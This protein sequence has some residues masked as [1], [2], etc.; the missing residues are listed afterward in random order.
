MWL[1]MGQAILTEPGDVTSCIEALL[2]LVEDNQL[3][4]R[5]ARNARERFLKHFTVKVHH[6][7][8][9]TAFSSLKP[10]EQAI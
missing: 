3:R 5:M 7:A 6:E 9:Q 10:S 1:K 2:L 4:A 8:L